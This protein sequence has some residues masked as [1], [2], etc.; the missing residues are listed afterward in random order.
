MGHPQGPTP[1]QFKNKYKHGILTGVLKQKQYKGIDMR[2]Y[3]LCDRSMEQKQFHTHWKR[4]EHNLGDYLKKTIHI[5][6]IKL[7][8]PSM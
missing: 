5:N 4:G 7:F 1:L 2:F 6:T 8:P 3:W